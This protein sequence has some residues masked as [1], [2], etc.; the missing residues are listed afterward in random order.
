MAENITPGVKPPDIINV[1]AFTLYL[2]QKKQ[3]D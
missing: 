2:N 1:R 3:S